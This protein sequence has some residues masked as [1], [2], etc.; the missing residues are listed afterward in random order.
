MDVGSAGSQIMESGMNAVVLLSGGLDSQ[1]LLAH[2]RP[3][4]E[5]VHCVGFYYGQ[6]HKRELKH[7]CQIARYYGATFEEVGLPMLNGSSLTGDGKI[8]QGLGFEDAR[9]SSTVVPNRNAVM[10]SVA[11]SIASARM[12]GVVLYAA[13]AGDAAVYPDCRP[14]FVDAMRDALRFGC[15]VTMLAPFTSMTKKDIVDLGRKLKVPMGDSWSC[16][17][18]GKS[19]CGQCGACVEREEAMR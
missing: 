7:A 19:P 1:V 17:V 2:V 10:L 15:G 3:K 18:G 5:Y 13:H 14:E 11:A 9:Q 12:A 8:P 16:Y 6:K 4:Y